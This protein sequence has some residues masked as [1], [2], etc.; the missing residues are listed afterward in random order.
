MPR[1][2]ERPRGGV[3]VDEWAT[4]FARR[5]SDSDRLA[6]QVGE[7]SPAV[8]HGVGLAAQHEMIVMVQALDER[9][10]ECG[11]NGVGRKEQQ[12]HED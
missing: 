5:A 9:P 1:R 2:S 7:R 10:D 12:G 8:P 4:Q 6:D 11:A 3:E